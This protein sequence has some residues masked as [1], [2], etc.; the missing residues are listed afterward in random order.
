MCLIILY[1]Y[2]NWGSKKFK[3]ENYRAFYES[4]VIEYWSYSYFVQTKPWYWKILWRILDFSIFIFSMINMPLKWHHIGIC[5]KN[6]KKID[7]LMKVQVLANVYSSTSIDIQAW[8][9]ITRAFWK[10]FIPIETHFDYVSII[11][12]N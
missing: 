6:C 8:K 2:K 9:Y 12:S 3:Y 7:V 11:L 1:N 4:N 10:M 5:S